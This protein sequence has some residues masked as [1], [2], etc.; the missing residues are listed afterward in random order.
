MCR[1]TSLQFTICACDPHLLPRVQNWITT[2]ICNQ[3]GRHPSKQLFHWDTAEWLSNRRGHLRVPCDEQRFLLCCSECLETL[4]FS[5]LRVWTDP[6]CQSN[7]AR[8]PIL[9][10]HSNDCGRTNS[11][12][13]AC[14]F[15][16]RGRMS[17]G[18]LEH[19]SCSRAWWAELS[20]K[21]ERSSGQR[22]SGQ[23]HTFWSCRWLWWIWSSVYVRSLILCTTS[24]LYQLVKNININC[25]R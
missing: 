2:C 21:P 14:I 11:V 5:A 23:A 9:T 18:V 10:N 13:R 4:S 8:S 25:L 24:L 6:A 7:C 15:G 17:L 20:G 12:M 3:D 16:T 22:R 19:V 1:Q